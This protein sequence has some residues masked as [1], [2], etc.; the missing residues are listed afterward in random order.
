MLASRYSAVHER[1]RGSKALLCVY[2]SLPCKPGCVGLCVAFETMCKSCWVTWLTVN[3]VV[4]VSA[5]LMLICCYRVRILFIIK[6][7]DVN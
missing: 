7:N 6:L 1:T 3:R 4:M 5:E 2:R